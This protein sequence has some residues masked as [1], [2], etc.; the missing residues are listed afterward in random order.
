[1]KS[2]IQSSDDPHSC[3]IYDVIT[4][5]LSSLLNDLCLRYSASRISR[6]YLSPGRCQT[7]LSIC[8]QSSSLYI[9]LRMFY[10]VFISKSAFI[11]LISSYGSS[12]CVFCH[13]WVT[14]INIKVLGRVNIPYISDY[15]LGKE[16]G[17]YVCLGDKACIVL[18]GIKS[19]AGTVISIGK[20]SLHG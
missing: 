11:P 9:F 6:N 16:M 8:P 5:A 10:I 15:I 14:S 2:Q 20:I 1:M 13:L 4:F 17:G 7:Q 19:R 18:E 12:G 3:S